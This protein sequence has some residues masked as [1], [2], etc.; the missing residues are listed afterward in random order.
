MLTMMPLGLVIS[1][2]LSTLIDNF[3]SSNSVTSSI[4]LLPFVP[5][6]I[7]WLLFFIMYTIS[8]HTKLSKKAVLLASFVTSLVWYISKTLFVLYVAHNQ[9]YLSIYG[10]FSILMF[11]FCLDL[12]L[13]DYLPLW[14]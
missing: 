4:N 1:F 5:Y 8:A 9:T 6:L 10:S 3:L 12:L 14:S 2:Y 13:L 7:I 11:F